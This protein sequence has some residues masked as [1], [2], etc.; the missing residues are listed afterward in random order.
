MTTVKQIHLPCHLC[1]GTGVV[2]LT[3]V[4]RDTLELVHAGPEWTAPEL[5]LLAQ[6][7]ATAMNNRLAYLEEK[8]LIVSRRYGRQRLYRRV[9]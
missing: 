5:A 1:H 9:P 4:F 6:C 7:K 3:G 8:G 2:E